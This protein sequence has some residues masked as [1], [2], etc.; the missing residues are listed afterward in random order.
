MTSNPHAI[1]RA[2]CC[3]VLMGAMLPGLATGQSTSIY[4]NDPGTPAARS[5]TQATEN[6]G[7][8]TAQG[9]TAASALDAPAASVAAPPDRLSSQ[10]GRVSLM[11]VG[12]PEPRRYAVNDLVTIVVR[13]SASNDSRASTSTEKE[14][15]IEGEITDLPR[16]DDLIALQLRQN[17][18]NGGGPRVGMGFER[19]FEGDGAV[20]RTDS[21]TTRITARILDI[22]P[23]GLLVLEARRF[24]RTDDETVKLILTGTGRAE[25]IALDNTILSTSLYDLHLVKE[26]TGEIRNAN[27]K[28]WLTRLFE[29]IFHF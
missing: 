11:S 8:L 19:S 16:L 25:D 17:Q 6:A 22:K 1:V 28:G 7:P 18:F 27:K 5:R 14:M 10:I 23:N 9:G 26:H 4:L 21:V 24:I 2:L 15:E 29:T 20:S 13:E 3:V 12:R